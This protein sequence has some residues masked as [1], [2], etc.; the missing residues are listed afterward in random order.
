MVTR[1]IFVG[2]LL[3]LTVAPSLASGNLLL[4]PSFEQ[5]R[6]SWVSLVT[7]GK[8]FWHD[9]SIAPDPKEPAGHCVRLDLTSAEAK[10]KTGIWGMVQEVMA[11]GGIPRY[12]RGRYFVADWHR[13]IPRQ[14]IQ[15]VF[16]VWPTEKRNLTGEETSADA[17]PVQ[18]AFVLAGISKPPFKIDNRKF[19]FSGTDEPRTGE[20]IDFEFDLHTAFKEH[21]GSL[22][23][24]FDAFRVL[25]EARFDGRRET[26][27][28][29]R[30]TVYF[31]DMYLGDESKAGS[32][33]IQATAA[34]K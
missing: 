30:A 11:S 3:G 7:P 18:L 17:V 12:L 22:P 1:S 10:E 34:G 9:F 25:C 28:V 21:W 19:V 31:D 24:K 2:L 14:Y 5:G 8:A 4:N 32:S 15:V 27:T 16:N 33:S 29:A 6:T 20:W 13:G 26:E 23:T